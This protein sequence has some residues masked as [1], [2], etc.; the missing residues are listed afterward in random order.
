MFPTV[1]RKWDNFS[2]SI[3]SIKAY[4]LQKR[5]EKNRKL[6]RLWLS[7]RLITEK[8]KLKAR[9]YHLLKPFIR[10]FNG[11]SKDSFCMEWRYRRAIQNGISQRQQKT[12]YSSLIFFFFSFLFLHSKQFK[13][14]TPQ[15]NSYFRIWNAV[16]LGSEI[17]LFSQLY[18]PW[19]N[20]ICS[21]D[22]IKAILYSQTS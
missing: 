8:V 21:S 14:S 10:S 3:F 5:Y 13:C 19:Q 2:S 17:I 4:T 9:L 7:L 15:K 11:R 20:G 22:R 16:V 1:K 12:A 6:P 18:N